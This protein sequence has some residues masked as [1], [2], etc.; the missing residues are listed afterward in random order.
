MIVI[1]GISYEGITIDCNA[2]APERKYLG[3]DLREV[4]RDTSRRLRQ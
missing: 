1:I 2:P 3:M 4:G